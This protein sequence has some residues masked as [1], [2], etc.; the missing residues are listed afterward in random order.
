MLTNSITVSRLQEVSGDRTSYSTLTAES[1]CIQMLSEEN[2]V[3][4]GGAIGKMYRIFLKENTDVEVEDKLIDENGTAYRV[5]AI[6][7]PASLGAFVHKQG[8]IE[9]V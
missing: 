8:I 4:I 2:T 1:A 7:I 5:R 9:I 6:T 3:N